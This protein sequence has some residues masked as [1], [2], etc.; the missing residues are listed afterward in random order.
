MGAGRSVP[1]LRLRSR[2]TKDASTQTVFETI[3][4]PEHAKDGL[5]LY[6]PRPGTQ[7]SLR[8]GAAEVGHL[9]AVK[10][11]LTLRKVLHGRRPCLVLNIKGRVV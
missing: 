9:S 1:P 8:N 2:S 10:T 6:T 11:N 3:A 5:E 4:S 7:I